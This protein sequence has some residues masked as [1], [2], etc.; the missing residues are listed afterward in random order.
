M[1]LSS[2]L[3][4]QPEMSQRE[5]LKLSSLSPIPDAENVSGD[6]APN[7]GRHKIDHFFIREGF[8]KLE[9]AQVCHVTHQGATNAFG[10]KRIETKTKCSPRAGSFPNGGNIV[11]EGSH[12]DSLVVQVR[13]LPPVIQHLRRVHV[14]SNPPRNGSQ[15]AP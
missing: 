14:S 5:C 11:V 15:L 2:C 12:W 6:E 4:F 3:K 8:G 1:M 13:L 10:K 9:L 7:R